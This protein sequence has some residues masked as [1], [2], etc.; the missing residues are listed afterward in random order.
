MSSIY[1]V[2]PSNFDF[3]FIPERLKIVS[4]IRAAEQKLRHTFNILFTNK[5]N[6]TISILEPW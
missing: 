4:E 1:R 2:G 5:T 6:G 3:Q